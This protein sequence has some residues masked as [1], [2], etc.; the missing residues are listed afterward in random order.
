MPLQRDVVLLITHS[1]DY[2]TIDRVAA[3]LS[4]RNVQSFRLDTDKFPMTVKIQAYFH[5]SNSHHQIEYGD[6]TLNTEQVQAVWMRRLWQPHL[7]PELAPQYRDACTKESLAVW[8]GFWDSLRHAHWVDDLQKINAAENKL[9][10]LRV[11]AEVGLVIPPTLV[12]NNPKEA[13]EFF[14]QVNGKMITKLLKPL[15]YS[16]EGSSFFMYTS[17]V[18]EE[19]LL[20]A[21]TLRYCPMVFQAQIPKQQELR[22]VYVNGNLFVGAL[23]ASSYEASTQDWRRANQESCTWQPYE[24][25]KEIIQHLDQFMARL[26]LTFG[27]FDFIVTPLEEY[28]FLEINP[29][30]EWGMLERDLNYPISEAIA[31]SLIQN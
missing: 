12:T 26:G 10:Q 3:A 19:D 7:S 29:T 13:R 25:P 20:D 16:M 21:E 28:V 30:G 31:D 14:E 17:T 22:A 18:K 11:A 23:D 15:S 2:F 1:G 4:R 8:D 9:Y 24:L 6:I 27:A 5:Q